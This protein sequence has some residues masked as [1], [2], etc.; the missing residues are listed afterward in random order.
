MT[1]PRRPRA[2]AALELP[3]EAIEWLRGGSGGAWVYF[4]PGE[5]IGAAWAAYRDAVI[6]EH[7][8]EHPGTRPLRW[9]EIDAKEP[10]R[11]IGGTGT[12]AAEVL[13][14]GPSFHY[15]LPAVWIT[16]A[17]VA[18]Y[19][20]TARD[21]HGKLIGIRP[22]GTKFAGVAI[23]PNDP[24]LFESEAS[25]LDRLGL[26]LPGERKRLTSDDFE[27]WRLEL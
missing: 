24:P 19:T 1:R 10:R 26:F 17:D 8:A 22:P 20:G 7:V 3:D 6:A 21:I 16:P 5:E 27:P 12:P 14:H 2:R 25:Y 13:A 4:T 18:L 23:D 9:W 11:R 15:G